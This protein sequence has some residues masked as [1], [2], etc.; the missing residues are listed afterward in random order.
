MH[1]LRKCLSLIGV[2]LIAGIA[3]SCTGPSGPPNIIFIM[4]D[5][6]GYGDVS[7]LNPESKIQTPYMD[8]LAA[9]GMTFTDAHSGSAVCTPTRYGVVT[10]RY[11][12][13]TRL[14]SG[15]LW[16]YSPPLVEEDR[17]TVASMLK[18]YGYY[19]GC[20]GKWHLGLGWQTTDNHVL[21]DKTNE[22]GSNV[23]FN[24]PLTA[25]PTTVGFDYF[26]GIP[27]SLDMFPYVYV[28]NDRI[29]AP[30]TELIDVNDHAGEGHW[31][32]GKIAP[33]FTHEGVLP[34]LTDKAVSF[35]AEHAESPFFLYFPLPAPHTPV[36]PTADFRGKSQ[37]GQ[38]GDFVM[39]VD[40]TIGQVMQALDDAGIADNTLLIVTSDNGPERH[41]VVRVDEYQHNSSAHLRGMKRD[42]WD[43]GHRVPYFVRW[44][45]QVEPGTISDETICLTDL[46][47]TAAAV[48]GDTLPD[49][50][51]EDSYSILP[52]LQ[53]VS[54]NAPIREATV[55]HSSRGAFAIRQGD[56]KLILTKGSGGNG[57][58]DG[59][60][61][62]K[63][64]D[65]PGQ[66]YYMPDDVSEQNNL[67]ND[68]PEIV[69]KLTKLLDQYKESGRSVRR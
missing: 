12:W 18:E 52:A 49:N 29:V 42:A 47:A 46:L 1:C 69:A 56:W 21:S 14:K 67:Y 7:N 38:Y 61:G 31:R 26:F 44:P 62:I 34:T 37:V 57:Y 32:A 43:G 22:E 60:D 30:A 20:I 50:A 45:G 51:G 64:S 19:T 13:R 41:K 4:A 5:D 59:P 53:G 25:G 48:V 23:D 17:T 28:E 33:G 65:P 6:L 39:Q 15:V 16:G 8:S 10:G 11:A 58:G 68:H 24:L 35:I 54:M 9:A 66:L 2:V 36:L 3:G 63:E 27:A 40:W 55:H